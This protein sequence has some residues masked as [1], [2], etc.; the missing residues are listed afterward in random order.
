MLFSGRACSQVIKHIYNNTFPNWETF[1]VSLK[2]ITVNA[3]ANECTQRPDLHSKRCTNSSRTMSFEREED[4]QML[5]VSVMHVQVCLLCLRKRIL[6]T[7]SWS[8]N[9][10]PSCAS[11]FGQPD[12][13]CCTKSKGKPLKQSQMTRSTAND[14]SATFKSPWVLEKLYVLLISYSECMCWQG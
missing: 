8:Y 9:S 7:A 11:G 5:K 2:V 13:S 12:Y 10:L 14:K 6:K 3:L 1:M 4:T